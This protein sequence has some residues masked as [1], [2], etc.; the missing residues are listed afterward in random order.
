MGRKRGKRCFPQRCDLQPIELLL[1]G[2]AMLPV[3]SLWTQRIIFAD[4]EIDLATDGRKKMD[5]QRS[6]LL[7]FQAIDGLPIGGT[8]GICELKLKSGILK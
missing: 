2:L 5:A 8:A 4:L 6:R 3:R 7:G 1:K